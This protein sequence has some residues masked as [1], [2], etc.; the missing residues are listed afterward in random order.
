LLLLV[1]AATANAQNWKAQTIAA[2][3]F[4]VSVP[5]ELE[6]VPEFN[7]EYGL[8]MAPARQHRYETYYAMVEAPAAEAR[9]GV[10][11]VQDPLR[12]ALI[13]TG[14]MADY[15]NYLG[16]IFFG[17]PKNDF[18]FRESNSVVVNGLK[19]LDHIYVRENPPG[20]PPRYT[21][22]RIFDDGTKSYVVV[23]RA[24]SKFD[25]QSEAAL[26]FLD[27]FRLTPAHPRRGRQRSPRH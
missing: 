2:A 6:S 21:H 22:G 16:R 10:V 14:T 4:T 23:Y 9:F 5:G 19:G 7:G 17:D 13:R 27:S 12:S 20:P 18:Y 25:L 15:Y 8:V 26:K 11:V 1:L 24:T 3:G